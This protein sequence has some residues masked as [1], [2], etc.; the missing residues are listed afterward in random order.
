[1]PAVDKD[2]A[3]RC[4][5]EFVRRQGLDSTFIEVSAVGGVVTLRGELR[6]VRGQSIDLQHELEVIMQNIRRLPGVRDVRSEVGV[7]TFGT[8][9]R[10]ETR[11]AWEEE[12]SAAPAPEDFG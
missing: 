8:T 4:R 2:L 7:R 5:R 10:A 11:K 1:M 6:P 3:I 9:R 12:T